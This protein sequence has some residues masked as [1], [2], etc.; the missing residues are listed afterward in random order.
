MQSAK[1][2]V[3][4]LCVFHNALHPVVDPSPTCFEPAAGRKDSFAISEAALDLRR[5]V[6]NKKGNCKKNA[7][8]VMLLGI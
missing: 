5:K 7:H 1:A 6:I 4:H 2:M 3:T 8:I